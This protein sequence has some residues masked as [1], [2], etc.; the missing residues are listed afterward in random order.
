MPYIII[1]NYTLTVNGNIF[2]S[3]YRSSITH[4]MLE[5]IKLIEKQVSNT[6]KIKYYT[7]PTIVDV[8]LDLH[9]EKSIFNTNYSN[10]EN[11]LDDL[12]EI[13]CRTYIPKIFKL[14]EVKNVQ[15]KLSIELLI[16]KSQSIKGNSKSVFNTFLNILDIRNQI[17]NIP[18][19]I[20]KDLRNIVEEYIISYQKGYDMYIAISAKNYII[21][22]LENEHYI[23]E[24]EYTI[25]ELKNKYVDKLE[26]M[27]IFIKNNNLIDDDV[28]II[29]EHSF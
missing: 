29:S 25:P 14:H 12:L 3:E 2:G 11:T 27:N 5:C 18:S 22:S 24:E 13:F 19:T 10:V 1:Q 7:D 16:T 26:Y 20:N 28:I 8:L 23:E 15:L 21:L 6:H 9:H 17:S 4:E